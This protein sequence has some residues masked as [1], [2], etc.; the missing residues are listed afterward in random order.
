MPF[1]KRLG[2]AA[3]MPVVTLLLCGLLITLTYQ[4]GVQRGMPAALEWGPGPI[5]YDMTLALSDTVYHFN[6]GY[7]G[8][9]AVFQK[10]WD[11]WTLGN[12]EASVIPRLTDAQI[13]NRGIAEAMA[14]GPLHPG[15]LSRHELMTGYYND[16][17]NVDYIKLSFWLFGAKIQ[18][19]YKLFFLVLGTSVLAYILAFPR[20]LLACATLVAI[21]FGFYAEM[22]SAI[23]SAYMP[24][25]Y[26]SRYP[27][28][29]AIIPTLH[30][31][32]LLIWR[33]PMSA[34]NFAL[35]A[36]QAVLLIFAIKVRGGAMWGYL[37]L[38]GIVA[39]YAAA[40]SVHAARVVG[41]R[42][43][44]DCQQV[45]FTSLLACL[46]WPLVLTMTLVVMHSTYMGIVLH[47]AYDSDDVLPHH[48]F[49]HTIF[50]NYAGFDSDVGEATMV[51]GE[52]TSGDE[53]GFTAAER[54]AKQT[55]LTDDPKTL[56]SQLTGTTMRIG[57]YDKLVRRIFFG[58]V[59]KHPSRALRIFLVKKPVGVIKAVDTAIAT[60]FPFWVVA[61]GIGIGT[62]FGIALLYLP[63][64]PVEAGELGLLL[65]LMVLGSMI[66][67]IAGAPG[68]VLYLSDV[69]IVWAA[70]FAIGIPLIGAFFAWCVKATMQG[71]NNH[72]IG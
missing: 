23:F 7:V 34:R 54:F 3:I 72:S 27:G 21:T 59:K 40:A 31:A 12:N 33:A 37:V 28:V 1:I 58:F 38:F 69:F 49:W 4:R 52:R 17:G 24:G 20:N 42:R 56:G 70:A 67:P 8:S 18:S 13:L 57:L 41:F 68:P 10:L 45:A 39:I 9:P 46:R 22:N 55:Y 47:P 66:P 15:Q 16:L 30:L 11:V 29:L 62:V 48:M 71:L 43:T 50:T 35:A 61:A 6:L 63:W 32:L 14:L 25:V 5:V 64:N 2:Q 19:L 60:Y 36:V 26:G 44:I 65:A 51:D 53:I